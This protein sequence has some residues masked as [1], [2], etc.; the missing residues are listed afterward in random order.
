M[1]DHLLAQQQEMR[2]HLA[3]YPDTY[4]VDKFADP[5]TYQMNK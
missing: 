2:D 3:K 1:P 4:P 5:S